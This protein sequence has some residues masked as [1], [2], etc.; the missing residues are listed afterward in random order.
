MRPMRPMRPRTHAHMHCSHACTRPCMPPIRLNQYTVSHARFPCTVSPM[1]HRPA[2][3]LGREA[4]R[5]DALWSL[6]SHPPVTLSG[7]HPPGAGPSK[8]AGFLS[9]RQH[10]EPAQPLAPSMQAEVINLSPF[11]P[12]PSWQPSLAP[13]TAAKNVKAAAAHTA[14]PDQHVQHAEVSAGWAPLLGG[15]PL[16]DLAGAA[17][18]SWR[19]SCPTIASPPLQSPIAVSVGGWVLGAGAGPRTKW[20]HSVEGGGVKFRIHAATV[21]CHTG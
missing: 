17:R 8:T 16:P 15:V 20:H 4:A 12:T 1:R 5:Q 11:H 6:P 2:S 21:P 13:L 14:Q 18:G 3:L 10:H 19:T 9:V 7:Q